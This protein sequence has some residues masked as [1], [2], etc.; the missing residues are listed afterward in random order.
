MRA[1]EPIHVR[2]YRNGLCITVDDSVPTEEICERVLGRIASLGSFIKGAS[3]VLEVGSHSLDDDALRAMQKRFE[4]E[5]GLSISQLITASD[6]TR[7]AAEI[8]RIRAAPTLLQQ[9]GIDLTEGREREPNAIT[10]RSTLRGGALERYLE[11]SILVMGDVN[12]GAEVVASGDIVVLGTVRGVVHAGA[13]GDEGA[14]VIALNL[15]ATQ[16]RI[17]QR[18]ARAPEGGRKAGV[19]P[20]IARIEEGQIVVSDFDGL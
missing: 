16:L 7:Q 5:H 11:G 10:I 8:L 12:P 1:N 17:A 3:I 6:E 9:R 20:E 15:N 14:G 4:R 13:M 19:R 2:G 18:I